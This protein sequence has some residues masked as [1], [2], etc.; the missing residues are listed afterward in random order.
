ME[1]ILIVDDQEVTRLILTEFVDKIGM[2]VRGKVFNGPL[3]AL[4]WLNDNSVVMAIVDYRMPGIDGIE[5][6]RRLH[7]LPHCRDVPV[8]MISVIDDPN[9]VVRYEA[10]E[11]GVLDFLPKPIDYTELLAR[12]RQILQLRRWYRKSQFH[13]DVTGILFQIAQLM[14]GTLGAWPVSVAGLLN[15]WVFP[16]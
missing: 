6:T 8:V 14:A 12:C 4:R 13:D 10:L 7:K 9:K 15:R 3:E 5:F 16:N 2:D 1:T 11:A